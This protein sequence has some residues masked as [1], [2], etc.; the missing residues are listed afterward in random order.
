VLRIA[1]DQP[2]ALAKREAV[3]RRYLSPSKVPSGVKP[4]LLTI[5]AEEMPDYLWMETG[6]P[7]HGEG[8]SSSY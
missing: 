6:Q 7:A 1:S 4:T 5:A 8:V 2:H 3:H